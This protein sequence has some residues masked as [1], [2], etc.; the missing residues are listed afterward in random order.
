M[1]FSKLQRGRS[2]F[3]QK[4]KLKPIGCVYCK[5]KGNPSW[6]NHT[7]KNDKGV[8]I[9]SSATLDRMARQISTKTFTSNTFTFI[10]LSSNK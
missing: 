4:H 9:C 2:V 7:M 1:T 8:I 5:N 3:E 6:V 10:W